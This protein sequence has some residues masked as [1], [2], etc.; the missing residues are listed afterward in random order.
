MIRKTYL[1]VITMGINKR[2]LALMLPV[3]FLL[4]CDGPPENPP[5]IRD[6]VSSGLEDE[7]EVPETPQPS[8]EHGVSKEE[9]AL[10]E[11][12]YTVLVG[13]FEQMNRAEQLAQ[14][15]RASRVNN[16]IYRKDGRW[17]VC[18]GRYATRKRAS[19]TAMLLHEKGFTSA[20]VIGPGN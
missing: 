16:F 4:A 8:P 6:G 17:R 19:S 5:S 10:G 14:E 15:L 7:I 20:V 18:V 3:L 11:Q 12:E 9:G 2:C 13:S 1:A